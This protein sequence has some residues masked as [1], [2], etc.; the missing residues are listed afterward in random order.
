MGYVLP[1]MGQVRRVGTSLWALWLAAPLVNACAQPPAP[2]AA[3]AP[4]TVK[5]GVERFLPLTDATVFAYDSLSEPSGEK[6]MLVLEVRRPRAELA[7]LS[8][9]GR[10]QRLE[11][12]ATGIRHL[13]GGWLLKLPL[14][15]GASWRGD[16]GT[17]EVTSLDRKLSVPAGQFGDCLETVESASGA[18]FDKRTTTAYCPGVGIAQRRTDVESNEGNGVESL[19]L[20]SFGPRVDLLR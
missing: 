1:V 13:T 11:I 8:V 5:G 2:A 6:G 19:T 17:V 18:D 14:V 12:D 7:E 4:Q 9:A 3:P 15:L 10:V 16:F 20:R